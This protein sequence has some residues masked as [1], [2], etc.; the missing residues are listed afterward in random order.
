[1]LCGCPPLVNSQ[2]ETRMRLTGIV[3]DSKSLPA[4]LQ[5]ETDTW[6]QPSETEAQ[7]DSDPV[8]PTTPTSA[9]RHSRADQRD[10]RKQRTQSNRS[11]QTNDPTHTTNINRKAN[12]NTVSAKR[13][14][15]ISANFIIKTAIV[16]RSGKVTPGESQ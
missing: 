11:N 6:E 14:I 15:G 5:T 3:L 10:P 2:Y 13:G 9:F 1:M 16:S 4:H 8:P 7:S 12:M